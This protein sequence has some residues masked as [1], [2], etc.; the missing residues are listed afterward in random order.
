M[1][2]SLATNPTKDVGWKGVWA[3]TWRCIVFAPLGMI[4]SATLLCVPIAAIFP[5]VI[6]AV[7][8]FYDLWWQGIAAFTV[9]SLLIVAWRSFRL[10]RL[11]TGPDSYL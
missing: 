6:G 1:A 4:V 2:S 7:C 10:G 9:W 8:L 11:F 5:P 3:V